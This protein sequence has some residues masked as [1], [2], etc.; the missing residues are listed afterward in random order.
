MAALTTPLGI[1]D[2][3]I[4]LDASDLA[5]MFLLGTGQNQVQSSG[6]PV[7]YWKN[8]AAWNSNLTSLNQLGTTVSG[9]SAFVQNTNVSRNPTFLYINNQN[10][11]V[12]FDGANDA[13]TAYFNNNYTS[14]TVFAVLSTNQ[15]YPTNGRLY[16]QSGITH[17]DTTTPNNI[18][19]IVA[20]TATLL[21]LYSTNPAL[22]T[23]SVTPRNK[24]DVFTST[25]NGTT[26]TTFLNG[27]QNTRSNSTLNASINVT[28][29]GMGIPAAGGI[30]FGANNTSVNFYLSELLCYNRSLTTEERTKVELYLGRKW[31]IT[32]RS[33]YAKQSGLW[34][35]PNTW[36]E[37]LVPLSTDHVYA[38]ANVVEINT[39]V[40]VQTIRN[41]A[42]NFNSISD[43][44]M[45][46]VTRPTTVTTLSAPGFINSSMTLLSSSVSDETQIGGGDTAVFQGNITGGNSN[47]SYGLHHVGSGGVLIIGNVK[48]GTGAQCGGVYYNGTG[49]IDIYG[50]IT[51]GSSLGP[52]LSADCSASSVYIHGNVLGGA[53]GGGPGYVLKGSFDTIDVEGTHIGGSG[54]NTT[55]GIIRGSVSTLNAQKTI[56]GGSSTSALGLQLSG[57]IPIN[58]VTVQG[59]ILGGTGTSAP[60]M[61]INIPI[62]N[63]TI[64]NNTPNASIEAGANTSSHGLSILAPVSG[65]ITIAN[66]NA[67][68]STSNHSSHGINVVADSV[69]EINGAVNGTSAGHGIYL[70]SDYT[71]LNNYHSSI[72]KVNGS[73]SAERSTANIRTGIYNYHG[74]VYVNGLVIGGGSSTTYGIQN[75][76][77]SVFVNGTV[78]GGS[79]GAGI[80]TS[81]ADERSTTNIVV[82]GNIVGGEGPEAYGVINESRYGVFQLFG[83]AI[84]S[85]TSSAFR[86]ARF[87]TGTNV[88]E[89]YGKYTQNYFS[90]NII[91]DPSGRVAIYSLT[92]QLHPPATNTVISYSSLNNEKLN[93]YSTDSLSAFSMPPVSAVREGVS[94][95][96][97]TLVGTCFIPSPKSVRLNTPV[98]NTVGEA[99]MDASD[100][101]NVLTAQL[102]AENTIGKLL[103]NSLTTDIAGKLIASW[104]DD[105]GDSN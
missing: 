16:S 102:T 93:M 53:A 27:I 56:S 70:Q 103:A 6:E 78:I 52:G 96:N 28:R 44:G 67:A 66:V 105:F 62:N 90:G 59:N 76:G 63:L 68:N 64:T 91:D 15:A 31:G 25:H 21:G 89:T 99:I 24:F 87:T 55:G 71:S 58:N 8:K 38:N 4:W 80:Q 79:L 92:Y 2:C 45:Y 10:P 23:G 48:G 47:S 73:V 40:E 98:D 22:N 36:I 11:T 19:P 50:N 18:L 26:G 57:N 9:I 20:S 49:N 75:L 32:E 69:L 42:Q 14:Q 34:T 30:T 3:L 85:P 41:V 35:D 97:N 100:F 101:Y 43:T 104:S 82:K 39:E 86:S 13:L 72:I 94:Y 7:A 84:A 95:A 77:G 61:E 1:S 60:G 54:P 33:T 46:T 29:L 5:S 37:E 81:L 88:S 12:W 17:T 65:V 74:T 83:N 51:G